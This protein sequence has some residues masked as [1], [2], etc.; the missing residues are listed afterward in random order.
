SHA[1]IPILDQQ[2]IHRELD[3]WL[4]T[5][6][7]VVL[8]AAACFYAYVR[9]RPRRAEV[10]VLRQLKSLNRRIAPVWRAVSPGLRPAPGSPDE[11]SQD[12][13][14]FLFVAVF[15]AFLFIFFLGADVAAW[16]FPR[17]M[18]VPF[19]LGGWMPFLSYLAGLGRQWRAPLIVGLFLATSTITLVV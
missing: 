16:L 14:R 12:L 7:V 1:N 9:W 6:A 15:I 5:L 4:T 18:A 10:R 8:I 11:A 17:A 3:F 19:I 13:G 2:E